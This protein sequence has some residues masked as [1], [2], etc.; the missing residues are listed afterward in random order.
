MSGFADGGLASSQINAGV[1]NS[2]DIEILSSKLLNGIEGIQPVVLVS[3]I[4]R[5]QNN[6]KNAQVRSS[7]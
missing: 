2:L 6:V 5:V 1:V 4:N 7:L 3:D